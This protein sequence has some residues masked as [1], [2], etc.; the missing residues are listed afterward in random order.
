MI[1]TYCGNTKNHQIKSNDDPLKNK[2][3]ISN[4]VLWLLSGGHMSQELWLKI[5]VRK[6]IVA[7]IAEK[8][9]ETYHNFSVMFEKN[10]P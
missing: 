10:K 4:V 8:V 9:Q 2:R 7:S 1:G 3:E 6:I 5:F